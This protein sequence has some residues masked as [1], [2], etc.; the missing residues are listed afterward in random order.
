MSHSVYK[1][2]FCLRSWQWEVNV[3]TCT[4][5]T[6]INSDGSFHVPKHCQHVFLYSLLCLELFFLLSFGISTLLTA[7]LTQV[8]DKP[9]F[10]PLVNSFLIKTCFS[11]HITHSP[12]NFTWFALLS[13][14]KFDKRPLFKSEALWFAAILNRL[15]TNS[16]TMLK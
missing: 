8:H 7:L 3:Y 6:E 12:I 10:N 9:M 1:V 15:E 2:K 11:M 14:Q 16:F 13:Y 4:S 5:F